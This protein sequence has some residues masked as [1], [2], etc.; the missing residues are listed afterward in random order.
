MSDLP[1]SDPTVALATE[2]APKW[3]KVL[4]VLVLVVVVGALILMLTGG[5]GGHSPARHGSLA[6]MGESRLS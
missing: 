6:P 2:G 4:G 1:E 3:V 5:A